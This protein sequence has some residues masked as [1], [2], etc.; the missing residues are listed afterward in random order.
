[1]NVR[2]L[3]DSDWAIDHL[4]GRPEIT[5]QLKSREPQGLGLSIVSLAEL[6]EG[7]INSRDLQVFLHSVTL[8][9]IDLETCRTFGRNTIAKR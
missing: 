3:V 5:Q 2:Y 8:V 9:G 1:M 7:V 6:Y 4:K